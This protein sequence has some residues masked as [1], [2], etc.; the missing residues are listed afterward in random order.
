M[1]RQ[2]KWRATAGTL[3]EVEKQPVSGSQGVVAANHPLAAAAGVE[4]LANGGNAFDAVVATLFTLSVVEPMMV[5]IF[6]AGWMNVRLADGSQVIIDNYATAPA[7]AGPDLFQPISES[8]PDYMETVERRNKLGYLAAGVPGTL[9][10]WAEVVTKWGCFDL[11]TV[12]QPAIRYAE[13]GFRASRYFRETIIDSQAE[14]AQFPATARTFLPDGQPPVVGTLITQPELAESLRTI[15]REGPEVLYGGALGQQIVADI[16]RNGGI[17]SNDDL[18]AYRTIQRAP[19]MAPYRG[20]DVVLPPPPCAGGVHILQILRLLEGFDLAALGF[21][22]TDAIHLLAEC[23]KIAFADRAVHLGDPA[24]LAV[25]VEWLISEA[26]ARQRRGEIDLRRATLPRAGQP[27]PLESANTTHLTVA[28]AAGNI[29]ACTQTINELFGAKVMVPG[30][31]IL[32]NNAMALFD[33]HPDRP[34]SVAAGQRMIS[35]MSPTIILKAGRPFMA[36][37]TPGGVRIFP[38]V[39]QAI[40]NVIDHG[41]TLQEAVEAPR[42]WTQGQELELEAAIPAPVR[43]QLAGRGHGLLEVTAVAGGMNG[44]IFDQ[45]T[46][47]IS[48]SACWRA[49][50]APVALGGG[51]ARPGVRF[52]PVVAPQQAG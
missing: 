4:M 13:I 49:D 16:A 1:S 5:G 23:F 51:P 17:L 31:G 25:P 9:K 38:S 8:W 46:G 30:T 26:Y 39:T 35:S 27:G 29:A 34:N 40:I 7:A 3:F 36:L 32:L 20:Y 48:G 44:V 47:Q 2:T 52:R 37:G 6:G 50:G 45:E 12:M 43:A 19:I 41:M 10:A 18:R 24:R 15:A 28:D 22:T 33:P 14:L 11:A 42:I 21:G